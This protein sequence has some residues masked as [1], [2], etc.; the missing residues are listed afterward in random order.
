MPWSLQTED[1]ARDI[2]EGTVAHLEVRVFVRALR[3]GGGWTELRRLPLDGLH[4][5]AGLEY[6][7]HE[8]EQFGCGE[9]RR[10]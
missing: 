10:G 7:L 9:Q 2:P 4:L 5:V 8:L 1:Y 3:G 6:G